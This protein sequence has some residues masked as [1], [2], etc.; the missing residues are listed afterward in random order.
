MS[1][2]PTYL[3]PDDGFFFLTRKKRKWLLE[4]QWSVCATMA[5]QRAPCSLW[6]S[7]QFRQGHI[8]N[9]SEVI[10]SILL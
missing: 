10:L 1:I 6:Y 8:L 4:G 2:L 7:D 5:N 9:Q 3:V